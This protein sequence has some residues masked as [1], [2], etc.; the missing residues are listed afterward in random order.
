CVS[1]VSPDA[2][3]CRT[4][5]GNGS[6][7]SFTFSVPLVG[8]PSESRQIIARREVL[9]G[10]GQSV[11]YTGYAEAALSYTPSATQ[12]IDLVLQS[13][14]STPVSFSLDSAGAPTFDLTG[15][16]SYGAFLNSAR[17]I[18]PDVLHV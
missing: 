15:A 12:V 10:D 13:S 3:R 4:V 9:D 8:E 17:E 16:I 11:G 6:A 18:A 14:S 1:A 7:N 5:T 2:S